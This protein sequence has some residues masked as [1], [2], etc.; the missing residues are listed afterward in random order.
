MAIRYLKFFLEYSN[1]I[2]A[3]RTRCKKD[4]IHLKREL[5]LFKEEIKT[6][7][8]IPENLKNKILSLDVRTNTEDWSVFRY[9][10]HLVIFYFFFLYIIIFSAMF[11]KYVRGEGEWV[12]KRVGKLKGEIENILEW[13][14][15][16]QIDELKQ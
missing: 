2:L 6:C 15:G 7:Q 12:D 8:N 4:V 13:D 5:D 3:K 11:P 1:D 16:N 14:V 9:A 10:T